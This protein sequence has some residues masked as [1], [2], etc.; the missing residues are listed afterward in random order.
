MGLTCVDKKLHDLSQ[1]VQVLKNE[2]YN[3]GCY[4]DDF[5]QT[6]LCDDNIS[7]EETKKQYE[8]IANNIDSAEQLEKDVIAYKNK[9]FSL[10]PLSDTEDDIKNLS[11]LML[12]SKVKIAEDIATLTKAQQQ[13]QNNIL[14]HKATIE[15]IKS[16]A[17]DLSCKLSN[18]KLLC[19]F[20]AFTHL[21]PR[22]ADSKIEQI[23]SAQNELENSLYSLGR[24][25]ELNP[26]V[27]QE[28]NSEIKK[29]IK[30]YEKGPDVDRQ[31]SDFKVDFHRE[32]VSSLQSLV[33]EVQSAIQIP[34]SLNISTSPSSQNLTSVA[35]K[36]DNSERILKLIKSK[37]PQL[38]I[39]IV[40][41][42]E[43]DQEETKYKT[44]D[45]SK[46]TEEF[47]QRMEARHKLSI[48]NEIDEAGFNVVIDG[49][50]KKADMPGIL[51]KREEN[52]AKLNK[53]IEKMKSF[54]SIRS[55]GVPYQN[56][57][58]GYQDYQEISYDKLTIFYA[59]DHL[60]HV[61]ENFNNLYRVT[62]IMSGIDKPAKP[63]ELV[64]ASRGLYRSWGN[65]RTFILEDRCLVYIASNDFHMH[66]I[67]NKCFE[68]R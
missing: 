1:Q 54:E 35:E 43:L 29:E 59:L 13:I 5:S 44:F 37:E 57:Y 7:L 66:S 41:V 36:Y 18:L 52:L 53:L 20:S 38:R 58:F 49:L 67:V 2:L 64:L 10:H 50:K 27:H 3:V 48:N 4:K 34:I 12:A 11:K 32:R 24:I 62:Q 8:L 19:D 17:T 65:S 16:K 39:S 15:K 63:I 28:T 51:L 60:I 14:E 6:L 21:S 22:E 9:N 47:L 30:I 33:A 31:I 25:L 68:T 61:F 26:R 56:N 45:P 23:Q 55:F 40:D 42:I 46:F